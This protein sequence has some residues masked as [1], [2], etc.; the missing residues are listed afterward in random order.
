MSEEKALEVIK[1]LLDQAVK[2]GMFANAESVVNA[3]VAFSILKK[4]IPE[5]E[6]KKE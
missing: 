1:E 4:L 6:V 5:P 2:Q 3:H